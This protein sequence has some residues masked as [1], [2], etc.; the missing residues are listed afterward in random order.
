MMV[1][2]SSDKRFGM[3]CVDQKGAGG[4]CGIRV[5]EATSAVTPPPVASVQFII[6]ERSSINFRQQLIL[7]ANDAGRFEKM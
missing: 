4:E 3:V 1:K 2:F 7:Y 6:Q 5:G